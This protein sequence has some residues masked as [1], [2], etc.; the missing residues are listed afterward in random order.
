MSAP[1]LWLAL[2]KTVVYGGLYVV[3]VLLLLLV[4]APF[5]HGYA[6]D[7]KIF[8]TAGHAYL[9][10]RS[11]YPPANA[12][13]LRKQ[14]SF[15]YPAPMAALFVP[16]ALL[17][18]KVGAVIFGCLLAACIAAT[19]RLLRIRDRR[20]Y[21]IAFLLLPVALGI[22]LG[23]F[24][25]VLALLVAVLWRYRD[26]TRPAG[27]AFAAIVV[28]KLFLAPL[29]VWLLVTRRWRAAVLGSAVAAAV[30]LVAWA[31]IGFASFTAY[32]RIL[33]L[34]ATGEERESFSL[35]SFGLAAGLDAH[36]AHLLAE[37][38]SGVLLVAAVVVGLRRPDARGGFVSFTLVLG[39]SLALS[40]I[41]WNHYFEVLLVPLALV[42]PT[43]RRIWIV[44][45]ALWGVPAQSYHQIVPIAVGVVAPAVALGWAIL[46]GLR[47]PEA[48]LSDV[49][50]PPNV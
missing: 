48:E 33:S 23:T 22:R 45:F 4:L 12:A 30:T 43:L 49:L 24:S 32:H 42:A 20:L 17:P 15:V 19:L 28:S 11:P 10:G 3:P 37:G 6:Y 46:R 5:H 2:R 16:F 27:L 18:V 21:S 44:P 9:H 29:V 38:A 39:A 40:P 34:L 8:R 1:T 25:P 26:R 50:R 41:V 13:V 35:S 36:W 31:P 47:V 14:H 7:Y